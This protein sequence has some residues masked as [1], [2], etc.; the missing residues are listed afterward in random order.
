MD[1]FLKKDFNPAANLITKDPNFEADITVYTDG[2]CSN[3]GQPNAKGG[4][5]VFFGKNDPRN[6]SQK[7][8]SYLNQ[9]NNVAE[10]QAI[11][12]AY[13]SL[14][15]EIAQ[16]KTILICSDSQ[17]A[18]GWATTTG[19]KYA[20]A[21]WKKKGGP[22]P[23]LNL[24]KEAYDLF[25]DSPNIKFLKV[26]AHTNGKDKHSIGNDGADRLANQAIGLDQCPY[27][28]KNDDLNGEFNDDFDDECAFENEI[29]PQ[30]IYL[31]VAYKDKEDAKTLGAKWDKD[32]K[33]WYIFEDNENLD[34]LVSKFSKESNNCHQFFNEAKETKQTKQEIKQKQEKIYLKVAYK[35]KDDAKARGARWDSEQKKWYI[36]KNNENL[37]ELVEKFG[38]E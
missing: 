1:K 5:G 28:A 32:S 31:Q 37:D 14:E 4:L 27:N 21:N 11:I 2:A 24:I 10:L 9:T 13:K 17:V 3:N 15:H 33:Q 25:K 38:E 22:I 35:D 20:F 16:G 30:K 6:I 36:F 34:E 19:E 29:T 18:I 26:E 23:N 7:L 8:A 12:I